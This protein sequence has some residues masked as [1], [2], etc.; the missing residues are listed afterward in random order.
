MS[1]LDTLKARTK[2]IPPQFTVFL[3]MAK[4]LGI[5]PV[6]EAKSWYYSV[7]PRRMLSSFKNTIRLQLKPQLELLSDK[8]LTDE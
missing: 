8:E 7:F 1:R 3:R 4:Y 2:T 5:T 6:G